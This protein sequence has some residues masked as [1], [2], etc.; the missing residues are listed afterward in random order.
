MRRNNRSLREMEFE[1]L[2]GTKV[3][4]KPN[5]KELGEKIGELI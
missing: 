4:F 1:V 3:K 2:E 5:A